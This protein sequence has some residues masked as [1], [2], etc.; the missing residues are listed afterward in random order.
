M[1]GL[2]SQ[3]FLYD[4]PW[5][6]VT[7]AFFLR[8]PNPMSG[9]VLACDV[10]SR[11]IT[12]S[13]TLHTT[14]LILKAGSLPKWFPRGMVS[15]AESWVIEE[16]E[17]DPFGRV[18]TCRTKNL[19][20]VKV[21]QVVESVSLREATSDSSKTLQ[22]TEARFISRFGW[23]LT[24]KIEKY[25]L[26]KFKTNIERSREGISIVLRLLRESRLQ[27][28]AIIPGSSDMVVDN[29]FQTRE[30]FQFT[31]PSFSSHRLA[32]TNIIGDSPTHPSISFGDVQRTEQATAPHHQKAPIGGRIG[33]WS[34]VK[35][36]LSW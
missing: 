33:F 29:H 13:G 3:T 2:F 23:G 9:H 18:V 21:V 10:I 16:S 26:T 17:I 24:K 35:T 25:G 8:Y 15:R 28:M 14:R 32:D 22:T 27:P 11:N 34:K 20:H 19:D 36:W 4:D 12:P 5:P 7:L 1:P 6:L 31:P 30:R